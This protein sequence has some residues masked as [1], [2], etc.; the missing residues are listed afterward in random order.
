MAA[1]YSEALASARPREM[2]V[3]SAV[4]MHPHLKETLVRLALHRGD[5]PGA[6]DLQRALREVGAAQGAHELDG[7][8]PAVGVGDARAVELVGGDPGGVEAPGR[9][10]RDG[11]QGAQRAAP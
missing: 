6:V 9:P 7:A 3:R 4:A 1:M 11:D 10:E 8:A 5:E 2:T